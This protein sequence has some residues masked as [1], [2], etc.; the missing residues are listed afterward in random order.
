MTASRRHDWYRTTGRSG[1]WV[2]PDW[3]QAGQ[4]HDGG[5]SRHHP[6]PGGG[7]L[8]SMSTIGPSVIGGWAPM[9]HGGSTTPNGPSRKPSGGAPPVTAA[10][11]SGYRPL[12]TPLIRVP[13]HGAT[14][15]IRICRNAQVGGADCEQGIASAT[16]RRH[17]NGP[18]PLGAIRA[19][20]PDFPLLPPV[21]RP[22]G[23]FLICRGWRGRSCRIE[24]VRRS[25]T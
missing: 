21:A 23:N 14:L 17:G 4:H 15:H 9:P 19:G 7:A 3:S 10:S 11:R 5:R 12:T 24:D 16:G 20:R 22:R 25:A 8:P 6:V 13:R 1:P 2:I 18:G